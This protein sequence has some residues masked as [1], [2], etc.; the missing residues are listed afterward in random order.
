M[1][2]RPK[3]KSVSDFAHVRPL[4]VLRMSP[5]RNNGAGNDL[6]KIEASGLTDSRPKV[7]AGFSWEAR[8]F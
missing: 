4:V 7:V 5:S 3:K 6:R 2:R 8:S 1:N